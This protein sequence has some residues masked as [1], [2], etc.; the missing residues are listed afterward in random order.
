MFNGNYHLASSSPCIGAG[1]V[2]P[3]MTGAQDLDGNPRV[4]G[5]SVDMGAYESAAPPIL[6]IQRSGPNVILRWPSAGTA[7]LVLQQSYDLASS[8]SWT[9]SGATITDDG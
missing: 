5:A 1:I 7:G 3:W 8:S 6:S 4:T 9:P 2:Q